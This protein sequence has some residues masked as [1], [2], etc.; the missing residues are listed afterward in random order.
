M[1]K[2]KIKLLMV[3]DERDFLNSLTKRLGKRDF[4]TT[5]STEGNLAIE[6]AKKGRF[7]VA[8]LDMK[9]PGMNGM[10]LLR[11]LKQKHKYLE[12]V[13][14]TGYG[15]VDSA[16]EAM[17]KGAYSYL[18]KPF[19]F[20]KLLEVIKK[21]YGA[22]LKKKFEYDK[23]RKKEIEMLIMGSSPIGIL[24]SLIKIDDDIQ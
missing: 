6:I 2:E 4:D 20:E 22:R 8:I 1:D 19:D 9:M 18:E 13:I 12:I 15:G 3:D 5:T 16:V 10:E 7:D 23:K 21:A 14:L 11:I 24:R 17:D